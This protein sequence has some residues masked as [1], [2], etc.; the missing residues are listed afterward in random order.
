MLSLLMRRNGVRQ[1]RV[2]HGHSNGTT[3]EM[4]ASEDRFESQHLSD[5]TGTRIC[6]ALYVDRGWPHDP[7][8]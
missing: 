3:T 1:L 4:I 6:S 7:A 5:V 8:G 2:D